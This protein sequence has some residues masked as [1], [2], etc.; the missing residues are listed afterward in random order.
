MDTRHGRFKISTCK[1]K[2]AYHCPQVLTD[3]N[4]DFS[5]LLYISRHIQFYLICKAE[6]KCFPLTS[7]TI[8]YSSFSSIWRQGPMS[9]FSRLGL[10][11]VSTLFLQWYCS[12]LFTYISKSVT[13]PFI[14]CSVCLYFPSVKHFY[15]TA[16]NFVCKINNKIIK[17][18]VK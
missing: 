18:R 12:I 2:F 8:T 17:N 14:L 10:V 6:T 11:I 13:L 7:R 9:L 4:T 3:I 16:I 15:K 5:Q 1:C